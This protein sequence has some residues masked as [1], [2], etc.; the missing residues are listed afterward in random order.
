MQPMP[1]RRLHLVKQA[2]HLAALGGL[3]APLFGCQT[4][5]TSIGTA[6]QVRIIDASPDAP[7]LDIYQNTSVIAYNMGF[8]TITSYVPITPD[9]YT[10]S[11]VTA[12]SKQQLVANKATFGSNQQRTVLISNVAASME[13]LVLLDQSQPAPPGEVSVRI[14][15][16]A[17]RIGGVDVYLVP[18]RQKITAVNPLVTNV[19]F[20]TNT[21]YLNIPT[22]GYTLVLVPTGTVPTATAVPTYTGSDITYPA[23]SART[24][25]LLD[26][27]LL[28]N[29]GFQVIIANDYDLS[30]STS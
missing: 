22:G 5:A 23:G 14:I 1:D 26:Q 12:G 20:S 17:T 25:I 4:M 30:T 19:S 2:A 3:L 15:D 24:I 29:P 28:N 9:V 21:G 27:I 8:G 16:Q 10:I 11:A 18:D 13:E 6:S 7:G